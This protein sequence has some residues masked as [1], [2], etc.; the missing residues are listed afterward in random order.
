MGTL[1]APFTSATNTG[2]TISAGQE[3]GRFYWNIAADGSM[4]ITKVSPKCQTRPIDTC[5]SA[6]QVS[7]VGYTGTSGSSNV[8]TWKVTDSASGGVLAIDSFT[9]QTVD[10]SRFPQGQWLLGHNGEFDL[11]LA[12]SDDGH[13]LILQ[14][15]DFGPT[16]PLQAPVVS[17]NQ[18]SVV[19]P[20]GSSTAIPIPTPFALK[21]GSQTTIPVLSWYD[22]VRLNASI[23]IG[24]SLQYEI[25]HKVQYP[26]GMDP[27]QVLVGDVEKTELHESYVWPVSPINGTALKASD[28]FYTMMPID[29]NQDWVAYGAGNEITLT[30]ATAGTIAHIDPHQGTYSE[31]HNFTWVQKTDGTVVFS[32]PEF[33]DVTMNFIASGVGGNKVL[34]GVPNPYTGQINYLIHDFVMDST[35]VINAS[36]LPGSYAIVDTDGSLVYETFHRDGTVTG[37]VGG[38]WFLDTNGDVVSYQ[39]TDLTGKDIAAYNTCYTAMGNVSSLTLGHLRRIRFIQ[40]NGN[41]LFS[42]YNSAFYGAMFNVTN[43]DYATIAWTYE[44][45]RL[46]DE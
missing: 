36:N 34:F 27:T 38:Y 12:A 45:I 43:R 46:G 32:F 31:T 41:V 30:S 3:T 29:F 9:R 26:S 21:N 25:H 37:T 23:N 35:P 19:F 14:M 24:Y 33:G 22:N 16:V 15:T 28:K 13:F 10:M 11:P 2:R 8:G 7:I 20:A 18:T 17:G 39:C 40:Q 42:K 44:W 1:D 4:Q 5:P 6:G